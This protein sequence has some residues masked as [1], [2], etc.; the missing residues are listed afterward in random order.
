MRG[1]YRFFILFLLICYYGFLTAG[2][3]EKTF[4][5][6]YSVL[7]DIRVNIE[8]VNGNIEATSW[9]ESKVD[10]RA[11]IR[12]KARSEKEAGQFLKMVTIEI[13]RGS[14]HLSVKPKWPKKENGGFFG[15]LMGKKP[16]VS[17]QFDIKLPKETN[18]KVRSVN[19]RL[20]LSDINGI[21]NLFTTNGNI[22]ADQIQGSVNA[23]P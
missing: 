19:G 13:D 22:E 6:S 18:A 5:E 8:N 16:Q 20:E 11:K 9:D 4:H 23:K 3:A 12:V 10:I 1:L 21:L 17:V 15:W 2:T 7:P 14:D